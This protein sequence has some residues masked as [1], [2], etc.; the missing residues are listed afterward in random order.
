MSEDY[1]KERIRAL[2]EQ[3]HKEIKSLQEVLE[4]ILC[5]DRDTKRLKSEYGV[6]QF[7]FILGS[8]I[9]YLV[10]FVLLYAN[11]L[12]SRDQPFVWFFYAISILLFVMFYRRKF[13]EPH[14]Q[15][16]SIVDLNN[17]IEAKVA[18]IEAMKNMLQFKAL[19]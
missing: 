17:L 15:S 18:K 4:S 6:R 14:N 19:K 8:I 16:K 7:G 5:H 3:E 9:V 13:I 2:I 1:Q 11:D 10:G 12:L